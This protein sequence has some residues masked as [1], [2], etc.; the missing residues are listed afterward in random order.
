MKIK[1]DRHLLVFLKQEVVQ[2]Q[3]AYA[4]RCGPDLGVGFAVVF[5]LRDMCLKRRRKVEA[6]EP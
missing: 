6:N 2:L 5:R 4:I 1:P 3:Q